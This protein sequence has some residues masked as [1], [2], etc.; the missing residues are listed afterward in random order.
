MDN[1]PRHITDKAKRKR[2]LAKERL[3]LSERTKIYASALLAD[4]DVNC[5]SENAY[6]FLLR[7]TDEVL[8]TYA[9][10]NKLS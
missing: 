2:A 7:A 5:P 6:A 10:E 3:C 9:K 8:V 1:G 4:V